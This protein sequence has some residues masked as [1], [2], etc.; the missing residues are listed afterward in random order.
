MPD[1]HGMNP[2]RSL[3][4]ALRALPEAAPQADLW[5]QLAQ[6]LAQR[7]RARAW[8]VALPAAL[9]AGV[10]LALLLPRVAERGAPIV[11]LMPAATPTP[12]QDTSTTTA[13]AT[14]NDVDTLR[15]R[16]HSLETWIAAVSAQAPQNG[17][18]LMAAVEVEDLIGVVDVQLDATRNDAE[19]LPLW[20]RRVDLLEDLATIRGAAALSVNGDARVAALQAI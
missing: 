1:S 14:T 9:A 12:T 10:A 11:A 18:D 2:S 17:R 19:A 13:A 8:R 15:R 3:A 5:P 16:S 6:S 7:R 4:D 20:K